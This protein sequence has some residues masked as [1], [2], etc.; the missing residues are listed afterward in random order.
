MQ[1]ESALANDYVGSSAPSYLAAPQGKPVSESKSDPPP[2]PPKEKESLRSE[3]DP[4]PQSKEVSPFSDPKS[5]P[6][7]ILRPGFVNVRPSIHS[8]GDRDAYEGIY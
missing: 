4:P 2:L 6:L 3:G 7:P 8:N 5:E 1:I